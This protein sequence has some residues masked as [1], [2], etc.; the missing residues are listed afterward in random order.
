MTDVVNLCLVW[1]SGLLKTH[2]GKAEDH[3]CHDFSSLSRQHCREVGVYVEGSPLCK[4]Y[5]TPHV[6]AW[7][8]DLTQST[9]QHV[10]YENWWACYFVTRV[11]LSCKYHIYSVSALILGLLQRD[12]GKYRAYKPERNNPGSSAA[13][14][15]RD[16]KAE[17]CLSGFHRHTWIL[18]LVFKAP[19]ILPHLR[20]CAIAKEPNCSQK[21][22]CP[23]QGCM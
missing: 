23:S 7:L 19:L 6:M 16:S 21:H 5:C 4:Y 1:L 2:E 22:S 11:V 13:L 12:M 9:S 15:V 17:D 8:P 20:S 10:S 3:T 18:G 14:T